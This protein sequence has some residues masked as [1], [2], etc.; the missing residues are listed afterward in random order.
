VIKSLSNYELIHCINNDGIISLYHARCRINDSTCI[1][2]IPAYES[3]PGTAIPFLKNE[4]EICSRTNHAGILKSSRIINTDNSCICEFQD[5]NVIPL[6][7]SPGSATSPFQAFFSTALSITGLIANIHDMGIVHR[8]LSLFSFLKDISSGKLYLTGFYV[9]AS[10]EG[11]PGS[12]SLPLFYP[13]NQSCMAPEQTGNIERTIDERTDLYSLGVILHELLCG[14][15][16]F[17]DSDPA[18]LMYSHVAR[19]PV[20]L[21]QRNRDIP[22]PLSAIIGKLLEKNPADRYQSATG[23]IA[24]LKE[25]RSYIVSGT[26]AIE[27]IPGSRDRITRLL[28]LKNIY[29]REHQLRSLKE[30]FLMAKNGHTAAVF[31]EG[32]AGVG[33]TSLI[34]S[35]RMS[36]EH[37][38]VLFAY[39]KCEASST[40][41]PYHA[42][43]GA[44]VELVRAI[45]SRGNEA[46]AH[47]RA[48][49][50]ETIGP[51]RD[52]VAEFVPEIKMIIGPCPQRKKDDN[53]DGG[54]QFQNVIIGFLGSFLQ[55]DTTL[56]LFIDDLQW[57]DS[58]L[59]NILIP[60]FFSSA[61]SKL[62]FIG[63]GR[64]SFD[65]SNPLCRATDDFNIH[66]V[67]H[68]LPALSIDTCRRMI[69]DALG[70]R[71]E[72]IGGLETLLYEKT[73]GNPLFLKTFMEMLIT[74]KLLT[75]HL[76]H[77]SDCT[78]G[79]QR[80]GWWKWNND[81]ILQLNF[82]EN[83]IDIVIDK[84]G[85]LPE[86]TQRIL[87]I[88]SCLG[89][90]FDCGIVAIMKKRTPSAVAESLVEALDAGILRRDAIIDRLG[91]Q[92]PLIYRF[93]HDR[94]REAIYQRIDPAERARLHLCAGR[95]LLEQRRSGTDTPTV[96]DIVKH[97]NPYRREIID[98]SERNELAWLNREA[99]MRSRNSNACEIA[100]V[101]LIA[102]INFLPE[103][104]WNTSAQL[105]FDCELAM[106]ECEY[107]L[108]RF[109]QAQE[110]LSNLETHAKRPQ[111]FAAIDL[112]RMSVH[113][114]RLRTDLSM[115]TGFIRLRALGTTL[116]SKPSIPYLIINMCRAA[117]AMRHIAHEV[118][119]NDMK[120]DAIPEEII[121]TFRI[122]GRL[123]L[124]A[125]TLQNIPVATAVA[126]HLILC[127]R[128][129]GLCGAASVATCFWGIIIGTLTRNPQKGLNYGNMAVAIARRFDD[130]FSRGVTFFLYGSFFAHI[131]GHLNNALDIL[132]EGR[133][134]S[135]EAGDI[136]SAANSTEGYLLFQALSGKNIHDIKKSAL[137]SIRFLELIGI[138]AKGLIVMKFI[139][140]WA[141]SMQERLSP[142]SDATIAE[143][144]ERIPM[145][146]GIVMIFSMLSAT[147]SGDYRSSWEIARKLRGN[148]IL[149]P[150]AYF[151]FFFI[152]LRALAVCSLHGELS[153]RQ[154]NRI[155]RRDLSVLRHGAD[156][157]PTNIEHFYLLIR[158]EQHRI[159]D[160]LWEALN[161]YRQAIDAARSQG[162]L[163]HAAIAAERAAIFM[164]P[165]NLE[166]S[167]SF[168]VQTMR[169]YHEWGCSAK[170]T[171]LRRENPDIPFNPVSQALLPGYSEIDIKALLESF[172]AISNELILDRLVEKLI[173]IVMEN[174]CAQ[175]GVL[176]LENQGS[177]LVRVEGVLD[178][179]VNAAPS[180]IESHSVNVPLERFAVP[181]TII[182]YVSRSR[183]PIR[184]ENAAEKGRFVHDPYIKKNCV[185]SV[186]CVPLA[187]KDRVRG[188]IYLENNTIEAAFPPSRLLPLKLLC[189]QAIISI[190][191]ALFHDIEIKHLQSK[192]NP[193]FIFNALS[194]I[195]ELCHVD[196]DVTEDAIIKLSTLYRYILT[197]EMR[198]VTLDEELEI[199]TKYLAI[200]KLRFGDRLSYDMHLS[201]DLSLVRIPCMLIQPLVENSI[202]HGISPRPAG[203]TI[204]ITIS[205]TTD[206]CDVTVEDNGVGHNSSNPGSGYG[207][208]SI[209]KRLALQYNDEAVFE[210][211]DTAG[212]KVHFSVPLDME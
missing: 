118:K 37:P 85:M 161:S 150:N 172:E 17:V 77:T 53:A 145:A 163:H 116:P 197:G 82:T 113:E 44:L 144:K 24:D 192:V 102:A 164:K 67:R 63:A 56:V 190:E 94:I 15:P 57:A 148:P 184:L 175:R 180:A 73:G 49:L 143:V 162:F 131:G 140:S 39:G 152:Y 174:V 48:L 11:M 141:E 137:E 105:R 98:P 212:F 114:H 196:P 65:K 120:T 71:Q 75:H 133:R 156:R 7:F 199:V 66:T 54:V 2:K 27:F 202:K 89:M 35:F 203:G 34:D 188:I 92:S 112:I 1:L 26:P 20:P 12:A 142:D 60:A 206:R 191:N 182:T 36:I 139:H 189:G 125:F 132:Y 204:T 166:D 100:I 18:S 129:Y 194:S 47:W 177:F 208:E 16:P 160:R 32:Q 154:C 207:L 187:N 88:A 83:V 115:E 62:L 106:A 210:I 183:E 173:R 3:I 64:N 124:N 169:L 33:K 178:N 198:L 170:V 159:N 70:S 157:S 107:L 90:Q 110:R 130:T 168:L 80:T 97:F 69:A 136:S 4:Y 122:L 41:V 146:K 23:V 22:E 6:A 61:E 181:Q 68:S 10:A 8:N 81:K 167:R 78:N 93:S 42:L 201:G 149:D 138:P 108:T 51:N 179:S 151:Y 185:K 128:K 158:A 74:R 109:E 153:K 95:A 59:M 84:A 38:D 40:T 127:T 19:A 126:L 30:A 209:R 135:Y 134:F 195:A 21:M 200:E 86:N 9:A 87:S 117:L 205:I 52:I 28:P 121:Y 99:A 25:C 165:F 91:A 101:H 176:M 147:I 50:L 14:E 72:D 76:P 211:N 111:Q 171:L 123:W 193:H 43:K 13:P 103:D 45:I 79:R 96:F 104:A 31:V 186:L 119:S 46:I 155:L 55:K 58:A 5:L 29:G